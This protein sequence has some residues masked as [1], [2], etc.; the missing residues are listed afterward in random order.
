M[1][2]KKDK[3]YILMADVI[4]SSEY[5]AKKLGHDLMHLVENVNSNMQDATLSPY[6]VT[7][8][9]EF[10]GVTKTLTTG[11]ETI[12]DF[13]KQLMAMVCGFKLRYVLHYGSIETEINQDTSHGM[14]GEGLAKARKQLSTKKRDRKRFM[15]SLDDEEISLQLN[16]LFEIMDGITQRWKIDDYSLI[17]SMIQFDS[18]SEVGEKHGKDRTQIYRRRKTL[19]INEYNLLKDFILA[20]AR[21]INL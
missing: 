15:F 1:S 11:I 18:D 20:Y 17:L 5:N 12:L 21:S 7:L 16:R 3:Y 19:L 8:G 14:L 4:S 6:T 13:E 10:Q 9:D 2:G